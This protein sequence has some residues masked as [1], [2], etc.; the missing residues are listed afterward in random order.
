MKLAQSEALDRR[1]ALEVID[2]ATAVIARWRE[3]AAAAG[4]PKARAEGVESELAWQAK[5]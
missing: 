1:I 2:E 3:F 5:L 4:V